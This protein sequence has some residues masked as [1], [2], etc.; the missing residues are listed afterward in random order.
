V[1]RS[2]FGKVILNPDSQIQAG[3]RTDSAQ[4][5]EQPWHAQIFALTHKLAQAGLYTW[6]EW[7]EQFSGALK[8]ARLAGGPADGSDYYEI[9][10][11]TF[12]K[13][14]VNLGLASPAEVSDMVAAWRHAYLNT[15]HG[16]P[17]KLPPD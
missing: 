8:Q 2:I 11:E 3:L 9:W 17:V 14:L 1:S 13:R 12:E 10:L 16:Q 15:P 4:P 6:T 7:A 5:F